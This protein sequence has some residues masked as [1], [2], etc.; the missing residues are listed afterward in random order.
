MAV[1]VYILVL[2]IVAFGSPGR[3]LPDGYSVAYANEAECRKHIPAIRRSFHRNPISRLV[4]LQSVACEK[5]EVK[6]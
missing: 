3:G 5:R 4:T 1:T 2:H 6:Q